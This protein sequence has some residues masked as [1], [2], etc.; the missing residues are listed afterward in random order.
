LH[1]AA[2]GF[3]LHEVTAKLREEGSWSGELINTRKDGRLA[4]VECQLQLESFGDRQLMLASSRD[5]TERKS[6]EKRQNLLLAELSHRVK[7]S[8]AIV[9][10]VAHQTMHNSP[11]AEEF[12]ERFDG[13]LLALAEAHNLLVE[14]DWEGADLA[15]LA[16]RQLHVFVREHPERVVI[17][18]ER[19]LLPADIATPFALILHE[20]ATNAAKYGSLSRP[21]GTVTLSW[22]FMQGNQPRGL[23]VAWQEK[24]GPRTQPPETAGFGS[25][26][27]QTAIS[28]ATVRR[29]FRDDGLLCT[30]DLVLPGASGNG[31]EG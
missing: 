9:Q 25:S 13:R 26:L 1:T 31:A 24:G 11:S 3:S 29:E 28:N 2:V 27:I 22:T 23:R 10:A 4:T 20:L 18:G 15:T 14:S 21:N 16:G 7:N 17:S 5:I 19:V 12:T 6:W 30:I 8:L